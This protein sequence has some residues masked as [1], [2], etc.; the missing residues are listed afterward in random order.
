MTYV[1]FTGLPASGKTRLARSIAP[2]LSLPVVDKDEILEA[3][4]DALG[5]GDAAWRD[6]LSRASDDVM[7]R[8]ARAL[9]DAALVSFWRREAVSES[10][11]TPTG[12]LAELP[13]SVVE[14]FCRC[15]PEVAARRFVA[16]TRHPGHLDATTGYHER[17]ARFRS[18]AGAYPVGL[19]EVVTVDT[20]ADADAL[21]GALGPRLHSWERGPTD[22]PSRQSG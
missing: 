13:G 14:V 21:L 8:A 9:R 4:Y 16:R 15:D 10:S 20:S 6:A 22:G 3:L 11:G 5:T 12:P 2:S 19:G 7:F 18:L 1:I 17:L